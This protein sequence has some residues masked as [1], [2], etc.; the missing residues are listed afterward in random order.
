M[1]AAILPPLLWQTRLQ[2]VACGSAFAIDFNDRKPNPL[3]NAPLNAPRHDD[4]LRCRTKELCKTP[5]LGFLPCNVRGEPR[6]AT[7]LA[8]NILDAFKEHDWLD[9]LTNEASITMLLYTPTLD[10]L[11][12]LYVRCRFDASGRLYPS[13]TLN[14]YTILGDTEQFWSWLALC[15]ATILIS[16]LRIAAMLRELALRR[17]KGRRGMIFDMLLAGVMCAFV[18]IS[19]YRRCFAKSAR[20]L[21]MPLLET[22]YG[23]TDITSRD[24][25]QLTLEKYFDVLDSLVEHFDAEVTQITVSFVIMLVSFVRMLFYLSIHP[26]IGVLSETVFA[27]L[28]NILHFLVAFFFVFIFLAWLGCWAMG[29]DSD[30]FST[31]DSA[32]NTSFQMLIGEYPFREVWKEG[33]L[34]RFWYMIYTFFIFFLSLNIFLAIIVEAFLDVKKRVDSYIVT[35]KAFLVDI[36]TI[37]RGSVWF[38]LRGLP[39]REELTQHLS[40]SKHMTGAATVSELVR[41]KFL[42]FKDKDKARELLTFYLNIVGEVILHAEEHQ[43]LRWRRDRRQLER[44]LV[45]HFGHGDIQELH[46]CASMIQACWRLRRARKAALPE[47]SPSKFLRPRRTVR[48]SKTCGPGSLKLQLTS[49]TRPLAAS[50]SPRCVKDAAADEKRAHSVVIPAGMV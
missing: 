11:T 36:M 34:Q 48:V 44:G 31:L 2:P 16:L 4:I 50:S 38:K 23:A 26:R 35:E 1:S 8:D 19:L 37:M 22:Y 33:N 17:L 39:S 10:S 28:D 14:T 42:R 30:L 41:S 21:T 3:Y 40:A 12:L 47:S 49:M 32:L 5:H 45:E 9:D 43:Q 6:Y 27:A 24:Q 29:R 25:V 15:T 18:S 7:F 13:F 46:R 20:D